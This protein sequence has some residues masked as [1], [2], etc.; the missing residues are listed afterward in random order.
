MRLAHAPESVNIIVVDM[1]SI[2]EAGMADMEA[3][4]ERDPA[5]DKYTQCILYFKGFQAIQC[6]RIAHW[7]WKKDRKV[8]CLSRVLLLGMCRMCSTCSMCI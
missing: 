8:R 5:C 2:L 7:L 1:Q 3:A 6:Q 4:R